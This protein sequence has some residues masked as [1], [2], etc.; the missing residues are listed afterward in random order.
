[1]VKTMFDHKKTEKFDI[2]AGYGKYEYD[3][4]TIND[5]DDL[6]ALINHYGAI[7][8]R[9]DYFSD[10]YKTIENNTGLSPVVQAKMK[11]YNANLCLT[12]LEDIKKNNI[13]IKQMVVNEQ[14]LNGTYKTYSF[15]FYHFSMVDA[16]D[17]L[18]RGIV[19]A[20][21]GL[22]NAAIK[23]FSLAI[24]LDPDN[25]MA[26]ECLEKINKG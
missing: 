17:Y 15:Y 8:R 26:K 19:Y 7:Y 3:F 20:N 18:E 1:M 21:S 9:F 25:R 12:L 10:G 22:H 11:E 4:F 14:K 6:G 2:G 16:G 13:G 24:R 23:Y 5:E